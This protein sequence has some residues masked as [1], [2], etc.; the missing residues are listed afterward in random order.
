MLNSKI[1]RWEETITYLLY[2][3]I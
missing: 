2:H 3:S 1:V